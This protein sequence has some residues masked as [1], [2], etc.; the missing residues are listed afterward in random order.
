MSNENVRI[1][2]KVKDGVT[3]GI[4][5]NTEIKDY[6]IQDSVFSKVSCEN[7]VGIYHSNVTVVSDEEIDEMVE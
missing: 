5:S 2:I 3:L 7:K 4:F 1:V 6:A